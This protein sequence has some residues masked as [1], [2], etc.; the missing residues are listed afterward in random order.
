MRGEN[1][2][3]KFKRR[4]GIGDLHVDPAGNGSLQWV[5]LF[6]NKDMFQG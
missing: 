4:R 1:N 6:L 5:M 2:C 3:V